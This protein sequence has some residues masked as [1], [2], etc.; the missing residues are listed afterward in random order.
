MCNGYV[1]NVFTAAKY[2]KK[3]RKTPGRCLSV[4]YLNLIVKFAG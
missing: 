1:I 3:E 4:I 2:K